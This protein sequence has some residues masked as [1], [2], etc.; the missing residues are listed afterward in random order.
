M[1]L[2]LADFQRLLRRALGGLDSTDLTNAEA[3]ELLN[4]GFWDIEDQFSFKSKESSYTTL[5][6]AAQTEY[7]LSGIGSLDA[8]RS[9]AVVDENGH[10]QP[11]ERITKEEWNEQF[12]DDDEG[13]PW[14]YFRE[15]DVLFVY[16]PS[17][18]TNAGNVL[19]ITVKESLASFV[20]STDTSLLP[21]NW[22]QIILMAAVEIQHFLN[23]D[24]G[25]MN[26]VR[27]I[28]LSKTRG[29]VETQSKEE[30]GSRYA[31]L[32]V[33]HERPSDTR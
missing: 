29:I 30:E 11:L 9:V 31:G 21:R 4:L 18:S 33:L 16:P 23:Q 2:T 15:N 5:L 12:D 8:V 10:R 27:N 28:R 22:D 32:E 7:D 6:V 17:D 20:A 14:G 19:D 25:K 13:L 1:S 24:Y 26:E 3:T